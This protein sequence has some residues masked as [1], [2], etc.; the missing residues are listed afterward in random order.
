M[1]CGT[2][3]Q[4]SLKGH[5]AS[6]NIV[7]Q[8][9]SIAMTGSIAIGGLLNTAYRHSKFF[10]DRQAHQAHRIHEITTIVAWSRTVTISGTWILLA[11]QT[12]IDHKRHQIYGKLGMLAGPVFALVYFLFYSQW[13]A[14]FAAHMKRGQTAGSNLGTWCTKLDVCS[15]IAPLASVLDDLPLKVNIAL[16][17]GVFAF[18]SETVGR[19]LM[20]TYGHGIESL[21]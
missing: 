8:L 6:N 20:E 5:T 17:V 21:P 4:Y 12:R 1:G 9:L 18:L 2:W 10:L 13:R 15:Q 14:V 11:M 3:V 7:L 16:C 19:G